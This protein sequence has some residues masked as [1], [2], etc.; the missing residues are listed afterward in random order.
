MGG[1][2]DLRARK[3]SWMSEVWGLNN[4]GKKNGVEMGKT[5]GGEEVGA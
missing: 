1:I 5:T 3:N 2:W 4:W